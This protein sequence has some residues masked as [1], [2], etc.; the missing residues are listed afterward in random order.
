MVLLSKKEK[1]DAVLDVEVLEPSDIVSQAYKSLDEQIK[2]LDEIPKGAKDKSDALLDLV[3]NVKKDIMQK[4]KDQ[5]EFI[6]ALHALNDQIGHAFHALM[7]ID[8]EHYRPQKD[9][10]L[11]SLPEI[12]QLPIQTQTSTSTMP[13]VVGQQSP[14]VIKKGMVSSFWEHMSN[15][16]WASAYEKAVE[17]QNRQ[18]EITTSKVIDIL[19]YGRQ[20]ESEF[21]RLHTFYDKAIKRIH[22]FNDENTIRNQMAEIR[23]ECVK[24]VG[25]ICAFSTAITEYRKERYGDRKVGVAAGVMYLLAAQYAGQRPY[26][27]PFSPSSQ[28]LGKRRD[29]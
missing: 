2:K 8:R 9:A 12:P 20:L 19:D 24:I 28:P 16:R 26:I 5:L 25:I 17:L 27:S 3:Y 14:T 23:L 15:R 6:K 10:N 18:P 13:M 11:P 29:E 21:M 4:P 1:S 22:F 7:E